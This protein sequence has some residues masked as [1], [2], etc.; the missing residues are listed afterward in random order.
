LHELKHIVRQLAMLGTRASAEKFKGKEA[1]QRKN[2]NS[3][4]KPLLVR[5][6]PKNSAIIMKK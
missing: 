5:V 1:G 3:T 4:I 2:E 6:R